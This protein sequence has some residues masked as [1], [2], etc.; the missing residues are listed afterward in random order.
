MSSGTVFERYE[1]LILLFISEGRTYEYISDYLIRQT[2]RS[3]GLSSRSLRRYC[4]SRGI[5]Y[6][7]RV[8]QVHLDDIVRSY[9]RRVGHSYGRRMMHGMLA[10]QEIHVSQARV[11]GSLQR[12]A[13][14]QYASRSRDAIALLNPLPYRAT[15]F[16]EKLHLDQNEKCVMFGVTHVV[17]VDGFSRKIVG[18]ITIPKKNPILIYDLLFRPLLQSQGLWDQV[19]VDHGTEFTLI[20]TAQQHLSNC[21]LNQSREP[22]LQSLSRQ[23]HRA[24]RIWPEVN[25][26]I[27]YPIKRLLITM[28]NNEEISMGDEVTRF[29]ISWVTIW[30]MKSA[31]EHFIQAWNF[32]RIPGPNGGVPSVLAHNCATTYLSH[33]DVPTI[34]EMIQLHE[35]DGSRLTRNVDFGHD[36]LSNN[37]ALQVL[38]ERDFCT[39]FPNSHMVFEDIIHNNGQLF[40]NCV[41]H[42]VLLSNRFVSLVS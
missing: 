3:Y 35:H 40:K 19:R 23:N 5:R 17:A 9:V 7:G 33:N 27:N 12:V 8:T 41:F 34:A 32:H 22:V 11:R 18:F 1:D 29:C 2:G 13:P 38:R 16:G 26:R 10:S 24:E 25:Q 42:F 20:I 15:Y 28:E 31:I 14:I 30:V 36:P 39:V 37:H 21:R 6:R 4:A